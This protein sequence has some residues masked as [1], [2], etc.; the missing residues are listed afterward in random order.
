L[1]CSSR[2]GLVGLDLVGELRD[3]G[4]A[5]VKQRRRHLTAPI[6]ATKLRAK[7]IGVGRKCGSTTASRRLPPNRVG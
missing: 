4:R 2:G 1:K 3:P 7:P 5:L 6:I